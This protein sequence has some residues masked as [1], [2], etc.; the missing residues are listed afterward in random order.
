MKSPK[1]V[2]EEMNLCSREDERGREKT[3]TAQ[4]SKRR[5]KKKKHRKGSAN[6]MM[7]VE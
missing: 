2:K 1:L 7:D 6:E 3:R 5:K 4:S